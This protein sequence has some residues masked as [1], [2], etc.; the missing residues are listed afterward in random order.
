[1]VAHAASALPVALR[2]PD[3]DALTHGWITHKTETLRRLLRCASNSS[4]GAS[5]QCLYKNGKV[6]QQ[7]LH[8]ILWL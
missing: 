8:Y 3:K 7:I 6:S 5:V 4:L 1:M 2:V